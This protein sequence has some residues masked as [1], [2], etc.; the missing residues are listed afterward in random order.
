MKKHGDTILIID[1]QP[2]NLKIL[3]SFLEQNNFA[4]RIAENGDRALSVLSNYHPDIILLDVIMPGTNGFDTCK[5]IKKNKDTAD[6][7]VIFMTSLNGTEDKIIGFE[8]GGVDYITK[9][10]QHAELLARV[11]THITLR[12]QNLDLKKALAEIKRLSG[13]L[14]ICSFCKNIRDDEGCWKQL[15]AYI[16]EHSEAIFTHSICQDCLIKHYE[17]LMS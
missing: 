6:I 9:P 12:R 10:I 13:I 8:A 1:D 16:T 2:A 5:L 14:P 3:L 15:E 7:P 4:V 17:E 11:N